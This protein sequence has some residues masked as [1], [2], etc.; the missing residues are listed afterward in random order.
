MHYNGGVGG[1]GGKQK[2]YTIY[3][4]RAASSMSLRATLGYVYENLNALFKLESVN[5]RNFSSTLLILITGADDVGGINLNHLHLWLD[6]F[7]F[8]TIF[9]F[10]F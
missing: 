1:V 6:I 5:I 7:L 9:I 2:S 10:N 4:A 8:H 3:A